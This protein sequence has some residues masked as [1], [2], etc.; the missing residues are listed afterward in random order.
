MGTGPSSA[1]HLLLTMPLLTLPTTPDG[2]MVEVLIGL[3]GKATA[4]L[5]SAG[6]P[7]PRP[8]LGR[9]IVDPGTNMTCVASTLLQ[10]LGLVPTRTTSTQTTGGSIPVTIFE[11]SLSIITPQ[12]VLATQ[13]TLEVMEMLVVLPGIDVLIGRDVLAE[14]FLFADGPGKQF[15]LAS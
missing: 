12:G 1:H 3:K 10:Q 13:D 14:C 11:A 5:V 15:S 8:I 7:V 4:S 6:T 2:Y 9:G